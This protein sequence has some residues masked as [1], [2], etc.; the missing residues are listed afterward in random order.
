VELGGNM[1]RSMDMSTQT[2][3][4]VKQAIGSLWEQKVVASCDKG[5]N[6]MIYKNLGLVNTL[7]ETQVKVQGSVQ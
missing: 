4:T 6:P 3:L 5:K 2:N 7:I 1:L